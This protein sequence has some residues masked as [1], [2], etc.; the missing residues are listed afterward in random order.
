MHMQ[1]INFPILAEFVDRAGI[2]RPIVGCSLLGRQE[3]FERYAELEMRL[4]QAEAN[5]HWE[6]LYEGDRRFS[7]L[8]K[9]CLELNGIEPDW[10]TFAQV[11]QFLLFRSEGEDYREGWLVELNRPKVGDRPAAKSKPLTLAEM[12]AAVASHTESISEALELANNVPAELLMDVLEARA[13]Q[14][15]PERAK[16]LEKQRRNEA[17][18]QDFN[19]LMAIDVSSKDTPIGVSFE[20]GL[21]G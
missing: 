12:L 9:R 1:Y 16:E 10:V 20:G 6:W 13:L 18:K 3:F 14:Q 21:D 8:V 17:L 19:Q 7:Y 2:T 4:R 11:E 15:N 5:Q